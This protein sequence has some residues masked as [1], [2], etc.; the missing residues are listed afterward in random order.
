MK[1]KNI[2]FTYIMWRKLLRL[3]KLPLSLLIFIITFVCFH[4]IKP[5]C[6]YEKNGSF[7]QFGV[8]FKHKTI[9][10][11]WVVSILLS[12]SSYLFILY[13]ISIG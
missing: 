3:Y 11:G 4:F 2:V 8:G 10:S 6:T 5:G 1:N 7:R 9:I 13:L 12:V